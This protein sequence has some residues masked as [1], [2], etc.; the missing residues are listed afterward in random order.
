MPVRLF[1][2]GRFGSLLVAFSLLV[3]FAN[4]QESCCDCDAA[5]MNLPD[6]SG[7]LPCRSTLTGDWHGYRTC[8][9][10]S[11]ITFTGDITQYYQGVTTGGL[12]RRFAY[13]GHSDYVVDLDMD[14]V[15]GREG[16]FIKLRGESQFGEFVS[17]DVGSILTE[18]TSSLLP[19][20]AEQRTAM[21]EVLF[22]QF[23]SEQFAIFAGK[24]QTF[25]GDQNAFAHGR[26]KTQFMNVALVASPTAFR[27]VPYSSL[28]A[29]FVI[30]QDL[31]PIF[32]FTVI[33]PIDRATN[34][35]LDDLF[36]EGVTL[37]AE[38]RLPTEFGGLPG[39]QLLGAI[40]SSREVALLSQNPR[41]LLPP[42]AGPLVR[43]PDSWSV[44]WNFDQYLVVDECDPSQGWGVFGRAAVADDDTNPLEW[45]LS[46]G[47]G[48]NSWI[49]CREAD[50]FG[51]GWFYS[52]TSDQLP[53]AVL[54]DHGQ[55]VELFYNYA[56]N[57]WL[58]VT[59][60]LQVIDPARQ[61]VDNAL[62][63]GLRVNMNL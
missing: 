41:L 8:F 19:S 57:P 33:D 23:L 36:E 13:G 37:V 58:H 29:G 18:N 49:E 2:N 9:A 5:A 59:G 24:L 1:G 43:R 32:T 51:V 17:R 62:V 11:G 40:W 25:D 6:Y 54:G 3:G 14:K 39:H 56:V 42:A 7:C 50:T 20:P 30:L 55:G 38:G 31:E 22:T 21:T 44:Y 45:F 46:F 53:G 15:A 12:R 35:G 28:G 48:G 10:E 26:G 47:V 27:T 52:S 4:A 63:L 34:F 61:G 60:D 16:L